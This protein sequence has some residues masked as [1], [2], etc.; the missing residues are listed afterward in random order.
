MV[1]KITSLSVATLLLISACSQ[2]PGSIVAFPELVRIKSSE[3]LAIRAGIDSD[4][5]PLGYATKGMIF[6]VIDARETWYLVTN[7]KGVIGW[8]PAD[9]RDF[10][11]LG[12]G[13][14]RVDAKRG[15]DV[16]TTVVVTEQGPVWRAYR[17]DV[18]YAYYALYSSL[19]ILPE[20]GFH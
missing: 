19:R 5:P 18:L 7:H 11:H 17:G 9:S 8:V 3:P 15:I 13:R 2:E 10:R 6:N 20:S 16:Q 4:A 12:G 14:L 1:K